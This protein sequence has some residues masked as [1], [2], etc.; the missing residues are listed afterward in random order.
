[1]SRVK[2]ENGQLIVTMQGARKF[3]T[4]KGE[5]AT[6]LH[7][8]EGAA[9]GLAWKELPDLF[10]KI[11]GTNAAFYYG[12][13]FVQEGDK[14]FFDLRKKEDAVVISLKDEN[15]K[16]LIIGVEDPEATVKYIEEALN[17]GD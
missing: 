7:N 16:R 6:P 10:D 13:T 12:G 4:L 15:F 9:V 1:M 8:V 5:I 14:V 2:I 3:F 17:Q 11:A